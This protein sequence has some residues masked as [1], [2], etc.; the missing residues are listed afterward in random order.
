MFENKTEK[1]FFDGTFYF[2]LDNMEIEGDPEAT[3][4]RVKLR[5]GRKIFKRL[6][7]SDLTK[8]WGYSYKYQFKCREHIMDERTLIRKIKEKPMKQIT[9]HGVP[10]NVYYWVRFID[11][12][13]YWYFQNDTDQHFR[14]KFNF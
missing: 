14:A 2:K 3:Q 10:E 9:Y 8:S 5:P 1:T 6:K 11:E 7:M 13:Y 4:W 12:R